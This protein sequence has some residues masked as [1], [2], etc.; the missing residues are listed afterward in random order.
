EDEFDK[1][2]DDKFLKL[3]ET[4]LLKDLTL[5]GISNISKAYMVHPTSDEKKRIIIDEKG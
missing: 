5:Q 1:I 2:T 3:I 4:N